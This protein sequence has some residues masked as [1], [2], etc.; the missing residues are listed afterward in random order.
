MSAVCFGRH[1]LECQLPRARNLR[2]YQAKP[3]RVVLP[4]KGEFSFWRIDRETVDWVG[5]AENEITT[6]G[7]LCTLGAQELV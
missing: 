1:D 4:V 6:G 2:R 7:E 5:S 3:V